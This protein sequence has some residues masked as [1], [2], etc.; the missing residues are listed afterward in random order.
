MV[1]AVSAAQRLGNHAVD[2][3]ELEQI[4]GREAERVRGLLG[5]LVTLPQN[6][7]AALGADH[8]VVGVLQDGDPVADADP[9]RAAAAAFADDH[10]DDR[11]GQA[12]H[13]IH[14][15]GDHPGLPALLGADPGVGARRIDE[16]D[17]R[18]SVLCRQPHLG[19]RLAVALGVRTAEEAGGPFLVRSSLLVTDHQDLVP[20][21]LGKPG[22]DGP[23]VAEVPVAVQLEELLEDQRQVVGRVGAVLVPGNLDRLP[24]IQMI[25][26]LL[27]HVGQF[28]AQSPD[29]VLRFRAAVSRAYQF[30]QAGF[31]FADRLLERQA[32]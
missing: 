13:L 20:V 4:L 30:L 25:V 26:D 18:Q 9:Q 8:R 2:D 11:R 6:T 24:G 21:Q 12:R 23:V 15:L 14:V 17:H 10:A 22:Q 27:G 32:G 19:H 29:F 31:E 16:R 28:A 7:R 1:V 5:V 3:P